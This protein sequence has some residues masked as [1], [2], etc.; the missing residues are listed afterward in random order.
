MTFT[1]NPSESGTSQRLLLVASAIV[2]PASLLWWIPAT[3][4]LRVIASDVRTAVPAST[5]KPQAKSQAKSQVKPPVAQEKPTPDIFK[6]GSESVVARTVGPAEGTRTVEGRKTRAY[7]G[8][9]DPGNSA[10]N[11]GTFSY[12][13]CDSRCTPEDADE[14]QLRRLRGQDAV[15]QAKAKAKGIKLTIEERLNGIDLA[16]Q[17]PLAALDYGGYIDW[18]KDAHKRGMKGEKAILHART[19]SFLDPRT[20]TWD[21]PGLGNRHDS[22][23]HD[24]D[25]RMGAIRS[26]IAAVRRQGLMSAGNSRN[27]RFL[28]WIAEILDLPTS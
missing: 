12:Q 7:G 8:H 5:V 18:L 20:Q 24:Q 17:A 28:R 11:L 22:I 27:L 16:N 2:L 26:A 9:V 15:I 4:R 10:W 25:R 13:H 3:P 19:W 1:F 21:A 23:A 6:G 14:R